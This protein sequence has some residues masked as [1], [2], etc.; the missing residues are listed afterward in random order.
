MIA[1]EQA[2]RVGMQELHGE[3]DSLKAATLNAQITRSRST[4][5][6][7]NRVKLRHQLIRSVVS[8]HLDTRDETDALLGHQVNAALHD[9][10]LKLH[11]RDAVHEQ[12]AH[13]VRAFEDHHRMPRAIE[14][15]GAGETRRA[16]A[17]DG[18]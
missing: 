7:D 12:A 11:V 1:I 2:F 5:A 16:R 8:S 6:E 17:Y 9:A 13:T 15:R 4:S 10:L 14:L 18:H 3:M